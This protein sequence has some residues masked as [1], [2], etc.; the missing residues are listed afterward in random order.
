MP[1]VL[2]SGGQ[3]PDHQSEFVETAIAWDRDFYCAFTV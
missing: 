3:S 1:E 2:N